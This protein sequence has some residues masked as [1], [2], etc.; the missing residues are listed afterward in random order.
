MSPQRKATGPQR[1]ATGHDAA[2]FL[3]AAIGHGM[4]TKACGGELQK[5]HRGSGT[6][7]AQFCVDAGRLTPIQAR[8]IDGLLRPESVA[9]GYEIVGLLGYGGIGVV[10]RA[11]QPSLDRV[12]ALKTIGGEELAATSAAARFQQEARAIARL[13]H[14]NIVTAYDYGRCSGRAADSRFYLA[15]EL[16]DGTDLD[17]YI[18]R[19]H[20]PEAVALGEREAWLIVQQVAAALAHAHEAGIVHR[21]IKPANLLLATPPAGYPLP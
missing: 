13:K 9:D 18:R 14:P 2:A 6:P 21:D 17:G 3:D 7:I 10:Y 15:M 11:R 16:V 5:K 8:A 19:R 1:N 20:G 12:V 4:L